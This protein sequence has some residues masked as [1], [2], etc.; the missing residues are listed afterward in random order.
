MIP[1]LLVIVVIVVVG[2]SVLAYRNRPEHSIESG[3]HSFK[4]EMRALAPPSRRRRPSEPG[5][6]EAPDLP[7]AG[8]RDQG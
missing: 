5:D 4:R 1:F 3:I 7:S 2:A 8:P 6:D